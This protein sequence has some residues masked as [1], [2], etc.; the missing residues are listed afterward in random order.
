MWVHEQQIK[1]KKNSLIIDFAK[2]SSFVVV[3]IFLCTH[4]NKIWVGFG[5]HPP[6]RRR[7]SL[8][9]Y[10]LRKIISSCVEVRKGNVCVY[11]CAT[12]IP[13][14]H[15]LTQSS[16]AVCHC[17]WCDWKDEMW[18]MKIPAMLFRLNNVYNHVLVREN[19][20]VFVYVLQA[21]SIDF[22]SCQF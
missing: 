22:I 13:L 10:N 4:G 20:R 14:S 11:L 2:R 18:K 8:D 19:A 7:G 21:Y 16:S 12:K 1:A 5:W 9:V 17:K 15:S 3:F 6:K